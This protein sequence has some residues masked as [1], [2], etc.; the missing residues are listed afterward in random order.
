MMMLPGTWL[1][2][3]LLNY[4]GMVYMIF[5]YSTAISANLIHQLKVGEL[6]DKLDVFD[7]HHFPAYSCTAET[8]IAAS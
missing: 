5:M 8:V 7:L 3:I 6:K 2:V 1:K 4:L